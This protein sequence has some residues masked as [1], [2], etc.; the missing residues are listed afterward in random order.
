MYVY[1]IIKSMYS[2]Y[3][4]LPNLPYHLISDKEMFDAFMYNT[5]NYFGYYYPNMLHDTVLGDTPYNDLK[6]AICYHI[7]K[8]VETGA[9]ENPYIPPDWVISYM[10]GVPIS[11]R[12]DLRET[13]YLNG[14]LG[15]YSDSNEFDTITSYHCYYESQRWIKK[16]IKT[17]YAEYKGQTINV[18]P[19]AVFGEPH[20]VKSGRL[21]DSDP[22]S[23]RPEIPDPFKPVD[24]YN[25]KVVTVVYKDPD[26]PTSQDQI[27]EFTSLANAITFL[28]TGTPE[29]GSAVTIKN[30]SCYISI[31]NETPISSVSQ[32]CFASIQSLW[33]ARLSQN[34]AEV[35]AG[36]FV[37]C[38]YLKEVVLGTAVSSIGDSAFQACTALETLNLP[39]SVR[40][41]GTAVFNGCTSLKKIKIPNGVTQLVQG[42]F[43][44]CTAL[45]EITIPSS[46]TDVYHVSPPTTS[47]ACVLYRAGLNADSLTIYVANPA[48]IP[49]DTYF[50]SCDTMK[51]PTVIQI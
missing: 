2:M 10:L 3:G 23:V 20:V 44:N 25:P 15:I 17:E 27:Y 31:G 28:R 8:A 22:F 5:V 46:I 51:T 37:S 1:D 48:F 39:D 21:F 9:S 14:L 16:Y 47:T 12:S 7:D 32:G 43:G 30:A 18:R 4:F 19:P 49:F 41:F 33:G 34:I 45:E 11:K 24:P 38:S 6:T 26:D 40:S 35:P 50:W 13:S 36:C 42:V 29:S